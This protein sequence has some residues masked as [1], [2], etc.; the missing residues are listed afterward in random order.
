MLHLAI[1]L[2]IATGSPNKESPQQ[3]AMSGVRRLTDVAV[4]QA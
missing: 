3:H 2:E 4:S 1:A